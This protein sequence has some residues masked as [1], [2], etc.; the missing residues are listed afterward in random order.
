MT[1]RRVYPDEAVKEWDFYESMIAKVAKRAR[2][3][4]TSEDVLTCLQL[5]SMQ[6]WRD[7]E[8]K[9]VAVTELQHYPLYKV[10]LIFMV[11]G[12]DVR[13]WLAE[14]QHQ[15]DSFA[16]S[17]NCSFVEFIGRPG[18]EKLVE[19]YGYTEKFLRMRKE[20]KP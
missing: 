15:L 16:Q 17:E 18:W 11:A 19:G 9:G 4:V 6:L 14:G 5:G 7:G 20:I 10:L 12:R 8:R 1:I 2:V 3:G 13:E